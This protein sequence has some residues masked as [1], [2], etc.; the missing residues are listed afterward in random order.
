MKFTTMKKSYLFLCLFLAGIGGYWYYNKN[1]TENSSL[2][3]W[4]SDKTL[5]LIESKPQKSLENPTNFQDFFLSEAFQTLEILQKLPFKSNFEQKKILFSL[6]PEGKEDL[7]FTIYIP[8]TEE[9]E[10]FVKKLQEL[11]TSTTGFR[12]IQHTTQGFKIREV[13][14]GKSEVVFSYLLQ[15]NLLIFSKSGVILED[16]VLNHKNEWAKNLV[17][18]SKELPTEPLKVYVNTSGILN[19]VDFIFEPEKQNFIKA[20]IALLPKQFFCQYNNTA[21]SNEG[22]FNIPNEGVFSELF[23]GQKSTKSDAAKVISNQSISLLRFGFSDVS[24][25]SSNLNSN[26]NDKLLSLRKSVE[27]KYDSDIDEILESIDGEIVSCRYEAGNQSVC[28]KNSDGKLVKY[29]D[30]LNSKVHLEEGLQLNYSIFGSFKIRSLPIKNFPSLLFG[31]TFDGF[32]QFYFTTYKEYIIAGNSQQ[33]LE[34]H[35]LDLTKGNTWSNSARNQKLLVKLNE[36]NLTLYFAPNKIWNSFNESLTPN[37]RLKVANLE[38]AFLQDQAFLAQARADLTPAQT[39]HRFEEFAGPEEKFIASKSWIKLDNISIPQGVN[40]EPLYLN[41][42]STRQPEILVQGIDNQINL[43]S[44]KKKIAQ[45]KITG[46]IIG[47]PK[48]IG[49]EDNIFI[50]TQKEVAFLKKSDSEKIDIEKTVVFDKSLSFDNFHLIK[51]TANNLLFFDN[52]GNGYSIDFKDNSFQKTNANTIFSSSFN[53]PIPTFEVKG[54]GY[55]I[56]LEERGKLNVISLK[57]KQLNGFPIELKSVFK[58]NP[59]IINSGGGLEIICISEKGELFKIDLAGKVKEKKQLFLPT[60]DQ[61]F[62][63]VQNVNNSDWLASRTDGKNITIIDK[64]EQELFTIKDLA[65]GRKKIFQQDLG[66]GLKVLLINTGNNYWLYD[67]QGDRLGQ[68]ALS[69]KY[70]PILNYSESYHKL[71]AKVVTS[72]TIETWS[73]K[74]NNL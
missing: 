11:S 14:D 1:K 18:K 45:Q 26:F 40:S 69:S 56:G 23:D 47:S 29:L 44:T 58:S 6:I 27:K 43:F 34:N 13:Y 9:D 68:K 5:L 25:F 72:N 19:A 37:W 3:D 20:M 74:L 8:L 22:F 48:I 71:L 49:G 54:E 12:S 50:L 65:F 66:N 53:E 39:T 2:L 46:K 24:E 61:R 38:A 31:Y 73:V 10:S 55:A 4:V 60:Q 42:S 67:L 17:F 7:D 32:N 63:F 62:A 30:E 35:L 70:L 59:M 16:L 28:I 41:N 15:D 21:R 33:T 57:G 64:N 36:S 52:L 51:A